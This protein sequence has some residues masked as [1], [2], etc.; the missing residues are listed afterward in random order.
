LAIA[1]ENAIGEEEEA[2]P[3]KTVWVVRMALVAVRD[4]DE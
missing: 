4:E 1:Y 2:S 3:G